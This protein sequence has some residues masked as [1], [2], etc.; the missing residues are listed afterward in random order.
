LNIGCHCLLTDELGGIWGSTKCMGLY[1]CLIWE[2]T[3][4]W[5]FHVESVWDS[6]QPSANN[7]GWR[8]MVVQY[9]ILIDDVLWIHACLLRWDRTN[10][11]K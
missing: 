8:N 11:W 9:I 7:I 6:M 2:R 1:Y 4:M 5:T 10:G 3:H